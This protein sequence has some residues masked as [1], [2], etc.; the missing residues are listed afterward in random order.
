MLRIGMDLH[1]Q[2]V[3]AGSNGRPRQI[4]YHI[5]LAAGRGTGATGQLYTVCGIEDHGIAHC[6]DDWKGTKVGDK[7]VIAEARPPLCDHDTIVCRR[8]CFFYHMIQIPGSEKLT[9]FN[10]DNLRLSRDFNNEICLTTEKG[11]YLEYVQ[12]LRRR[13]DFFETMD[14]GQQGNPV[15]FFDF[16]K[17]AKP[18]VKPW[19]SIGIQGRPVRLVIGK[20]C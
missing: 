19:T 20:G 15:M 1:E 16:L 4:G 8:Q 18:P 11:R 6:S 9:L 2:A 14:I 12:N 13:P 17:D 10:I 7:I 3:Y 5:P